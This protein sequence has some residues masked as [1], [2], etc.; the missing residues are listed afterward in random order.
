MAVSIPTAGQIVSNL[1]LVVPKQ[2][3]ECQDVSV[4]DGIDEG[5]AVISSVYRLTVRHDLHEKPYNNIR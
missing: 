5:E 4:M 3:V 1:L 2:T